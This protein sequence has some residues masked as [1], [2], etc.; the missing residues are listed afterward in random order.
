MNIVEI[1]G[2]RIR[3][4]H[5][6]AVQYG[7]GIGGI[8]IP[9]NKAIASWD[10]I[11]AADL[12]VFGHWHQFQWLRA[13]KYVANGSLIGHSAYATRIKASYEPPCQAMIVID[14]GRREVTRAMP[15]FCDRDLQKKKTS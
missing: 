5:G 2:F 13:S 4:H 9:V 1:D 12:T 7:G 6:H 3:F 10:R 11:Q 15:I 14:H 8:T